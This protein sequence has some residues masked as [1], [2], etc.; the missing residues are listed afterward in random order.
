MHEVVMRHVACQE[1]LLI[2]QTSRA[3]CLLGGT[4]GCSSGRD[5]LWVSNGCRGRFRCSRNGPDVHCASHNCSCVRA[6]PEPA[7]SFPCLIE[8]QEQYSTAACELD[9]SYGCYRDGRHPWL[10]PQRYSGWVQHGEKEAAVLVEAEASGTSIVKMWV[11]S[12]CRG[13]FRFGP[14]GDATLDCGTQDWLSFRRAMPLPSRPAQV[15]ESASQTDRELAHVSNCSAEWAPELQRLLPLPSVPSMFTPRR[16]YARDP[17]PPPKVP[18]VRLA[19]CTRPKP[20]TPAASG[21]LP[22]CMPL[23]P[24]GTGTVAATEML[25]RTWGCS[26]W[27]C[28]DRQPEARLH[29]DHTSRNNFSVGQWDRGTQ[30]PCLVLTLR[31]PVGR[32]QSGWR[33]R[34]QRSRL[35]GGFSLYDPNHTSKQTGRCNTCFATA[36]T[37]QPALHMGMHMCICIWACTCA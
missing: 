24:A 30:P 2:Q 11:A 19:A 3:A 1:P 18:R 33:L 4:Y 14:T 13:R 6:Q 12:G 20:L 21:Q 5:G 10:L 8:L 25:R 7:R 35:G 31:D 29:H 9:V 27:L 22:Y 28:A 34:L 15:P 37:H 26:Q 17:F 16:H 36:A 23:F 32:M